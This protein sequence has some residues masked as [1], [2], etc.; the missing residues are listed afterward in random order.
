MNYINDTYDQYTDIDGRSVKVPHGAPAPTTFTDLEGN[1]T[2]FVAE[3]EPNTSRDFNGEIIKVIRK[4][5]SR[6]RQAGTKMDGPTTYQVSMKSDKTRLVGTMYAKNVQKLMEMYGL[7]ISKGKSIAKLNKELKADRKDGILMP[8]LG[9]TNYFSSTNRQG[10]EVVNKAHW[11][12][13]I[14]ISDEVEEAADVSINS[15]AGLAPANSVV[16]ETPVKKEK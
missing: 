13:V 9:N 15:L 1:E 12:S 8:F 4:K 3:Y 2:P 14:I 6:A 7:D 11:L 10:V 16:D 5:V